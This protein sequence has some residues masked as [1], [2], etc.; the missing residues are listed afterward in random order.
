[1]GERK[2]NEPIGKCP[3][4]GKYRFVTRKAAKGYMHRYFPEEKMSVYKCRG[5]FHFG[6]TP[7][8]IRRGAE[9]RTYYN[10][11]TPD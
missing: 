3:D 6:H 1:M 5:Y 9:A 8:A 4:C 11:R 2:F 7:Y 10:G